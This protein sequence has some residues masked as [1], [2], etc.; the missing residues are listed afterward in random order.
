MAFS[1]KPKI[2][3]VDDVEVNLILLETVLRKEQAEIHK[4]SN[5]E[6]ALSMS[7]DLD[8]A[9]IIL[10]VSM[11]GMNGF[12]VAERLRDQEKNRLTPII[13]IS[14]IMYDQ[15]SIARGYQSGAVD[16]LTKPFQNEI[17]I[18]K[19]RIFLKLYQQNRELQAQ[20]KALNES[21]LRYQ[22]AEQ[23][24]VF[25][26]QFERAVSLASA[27]FSGNFDPDSSIDFMLLDM[28]RLCGAASAVF[29]YF[30]RKDHLT[31]H[32]GNTGSGMARTT[33]GKPEKD[34]INQAL[35]GNEEVCRVMVSQ[36]GLAGPWINPAALP[37][38]GSPA[39]SVA[40]PV[41]VAETLTGVILLNDCT[42]LHQWEKQ[43]ICALG[44]FGT[45]TG[46]ALERSR[47]RAALEASE[48]KYRSYIESAPEGILVADKKGLITEVNPAA[49]K[50][51][52]TNRENFIQKDINKI[53]NPETLAGNYPDFQGLTSGEGIRAEFFITAGKTSRII[54]AESSRLPDKNY[55]I[56]CTDITTAREMEK[57]LIHTERMVGIGEMATGIAH[58]I[59]QPLNTISFGI[60]NLMHAIS[61]NQA[62][63]EYIREKSRK[64]FEGIHRMRT[65]IDHVR[66][67]SRNNDDFIHS[68]FSA[69][70][71]ILN[72]LSLISEQ[73]KSRGFEVVTE[74][75]DEE[76]VLA[77]GNT[78]KIEQVILNLLS[79]ARD[80]MEEM[81]KPGDT[82]YI[83]RIIISSGRE[84]QKICIHVTDNGSGIEPEHMEHI[85][86][87]FFTTKEPGKGTGLGLAISYGI[88]KEHKGEMIFSS[89]PGTGTKVTLKL[90]ATPDQTKNKS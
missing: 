57:H 22:K 38:S 18:S 15:Q 12:E 1:D 36:N 44:V 13:F 83:P 16:Y 67:F 63:E 75:A 52:N 49:R 33:P 6:T 5:G 24:I 30:D 50:I 37:A 20:S 89:A 39:V 79:N 28:E 19:V 11:P 35:A 69:N 51:F 29:T 58:E 72:A 71:A 34:A 64:I 87:P 48:S 78:Y 61:S 40:I 3:I 66:T 88:M 62:N 26:Y 77:M 68:K 45:I 7:N 54:K 10:D 9:L 2:L 84:G 86:A 53:L 65:I 80:A 90:P 42:D 82:G 25:K 73:L 21:L 56:F 43:D 23:T 4:A 31:G 70:E 14:A 46:N 27:R 85:T 8:F 76:E 59:N 74:L 32:T 41:N 47:T 81:Q 17:L 55:L 60:D